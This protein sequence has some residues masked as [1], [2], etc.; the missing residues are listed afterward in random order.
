MGGGGE[1]NQG[2]FTKSLGHWW[3]STQKN[4]KKKTLE[5]GNF[6]VGKKINQKGGKWKEFY[7]GW[8]EDFSQC[9]HSTCYHHRK[10]VIIITSLS[11]SLSKVISES[12]KK[13][14][15]KHKI[16]N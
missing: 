3:G 9:N 13:K 4:I 14:G 2:Y 6:R 11:W 5:W 10:E 1:R 12:E 8:G 16:R 7:P 15:G